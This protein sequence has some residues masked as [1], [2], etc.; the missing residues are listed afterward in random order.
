[1][2]AAAVLVGSA[3]IVILCWELSRDLIVEPREASC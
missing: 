2:F 1:M 3:G